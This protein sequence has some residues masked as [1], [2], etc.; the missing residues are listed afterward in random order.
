[1]SPFRLQ[2]GDIPTPSP[3]LWEGA[4]ATPPTLASDR[5]HAHPAPLGPGRGQAHAPPAISYRMG[6]SP[7][8]PSRGPSPRLPSG[9]RWVPAPHFPPSSIRELSPPLLFTSRRESTPRPLPAPVG[10]RLRLLSS[11]RK[12][13]SPR[14]RSRM[15]HA[16]DS[17]PAPR[18]SQPHAFPP[19]SGEGKG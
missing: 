3:Q 6:P 8:L 17:P 4:K 15:G 11:S 14:L 13:P 2:E 12:G 16:Y 18:G 5:G 7:R 1:M 9:S 10:P 19:A